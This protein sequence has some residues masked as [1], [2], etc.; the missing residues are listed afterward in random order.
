[1]K[2]IWEMEQ[3]NLGKEFERQCLEAGVEIEDTRYFC[4]EGVV[5]EFKSAKDL[6]TVIPEYV[7]LGMQDPD[8]F[9]FTVTCTEDTYLL[10]DQYSNLD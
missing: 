2:S 3:F 7:E 1:M 8:G 10:F 6:I 4:N 9:K 5:Y